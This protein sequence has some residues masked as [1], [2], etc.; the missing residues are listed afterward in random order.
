MKFSSLKFFLRS[1]TILRQF[2]F[3]MATEGSDPKFCEKSPRKIRRFLGVEGFENR[4]NDII[5]C[6]NGLTK[7]FVVFFPGDAQDFPEKMLEH[8]DN[9][10]YLKW[11]LEATAEILAKRFGPDAQIFVVR[12]SKMYLGTFA[13]FENFVKCDQVGSPK[14]EIEGQNSI[15]HLRLLLANV[16]SLLEKEA[17][18][19]RNFEIF[20]NF[21]FQILNFLS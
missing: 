17:K 16:E 7:N 5:F 9:K 6:G 10:R 8:R 4:R 21:C 12:P 2:F 18:V 1:A 3:L 15:D 13:Q 14:F 20:E 19:C 11:N